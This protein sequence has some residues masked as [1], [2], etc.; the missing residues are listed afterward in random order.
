MTD[1]DDSQVDDIDLAVVAYREDGAWVLEELPDDALADLESLADELGDYPTPAL[2]MLTVAED[3]ALLVRGAVRPRLVLSDV[4]AAVDWELAR[5]A[6]V[7][8]GVDV[9]EDEEPVAAG[10][11]ALLADVG[12]SADDL[13][14]LLEQDLDP[15]E[16]VVEIAERLGFEDE[17][18]DLLDELD[19]TEE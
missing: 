10:D 14:D 4:S 3:F 17:L 1:L 13:V 19:E 7:H 5:A 16:L 8:L 6:A 2:A 11:M 15:E 12:I 18:E 9:E